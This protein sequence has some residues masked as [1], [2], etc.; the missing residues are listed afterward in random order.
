MLWPA[1]SLPSH[2]VTAKGG[3]AESE[4]RP[5]H[6]PELCSRKAWLGLGQGLGLGLGLG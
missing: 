3:G 4:K 5:A 6:K 1:S 2:G